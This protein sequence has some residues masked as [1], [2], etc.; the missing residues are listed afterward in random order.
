MRA[1]FS[2]LTAALR[3]TPAMPNL[4]INDVLPEL[5]HHLRRSP[6]TVLQAPPGAGKTT[7]VPLA[8]LAQEVLPDG[9]NIMMLEPRRLAA[10]SAAQRMADMLG[11]PLGRTVGY[12]VRGDSM[13]SEHT[14]ILVVTE[15]LL[16]RRLQTDPELRGFS[17]VIFDEF[18]ERSLHADLSLA[19][20]LQS[21]SAWREDLKLLLMSA[22]L[23][24]QAIAKLFDGAPIV[25]SAGRSYPV[26]IH[27][28]SP[29]EPS[30]DRHN[31]IGCISHLLQKIIAEHPGNI[32]VF[33]PGV[34]EIKQL[35]AALE[36][37]RDNNT[38]IAPLFGDLSKQQQHQAIAAPPPGQR[39]IVLA[40]NIAETSI[41]IDGITSVIDSGLMR[42]NRFD[43]NTGMNRLTTCRISRDSA[44]QRAGRA[45]RLSAGRCYRLWTQAQHQ[46]LAQHHSPEI[47]S[48]D[49]AP[50]VL[51]AAH[52]G[53]QDINEFS[54][55]DAPPPGA[56]AQAQDLLEQL[57]ALSR[58]MRI[59]QHGQSMLA[60]GIHPRLAH[61][62]LASVALGCPGQACL[63]A[64]LLSERDIFKPGTARTA[65]IA[66]RIQVLQ[67]GRKDP[68]SRP[69]A[70]QQVKQQAR[71]LQQK[72][73]TLAAHSSD[74]ADL[75][76][77]GVLLAHAY[78]ER[79]AQLR[80]N[81][82]QRYLLCG[83]KGA[84]FTQT[85]D[86]AHQ[87]YLVIAELDGRQRE[88]A[89]F[90]AATI[91]ADQLE[92]HF[93]ER[94]ETQSHIYW[95]SKQQR[96][97]AEQR[98]SLGAL[99]LS[100]SRMQDA[101]AEALHR[102]LLDGIREQGLDCLPWDKASRNL[103]ARINFL[104]QAEA[105][106]A[107]LR[108][109][110]PDYS[111]AHL[112]AHLDDWLLPHLNRHTSLDKLKT[113]KLYSI[114]HDT[115]SWE[116][117]QQLEQLAPS[118]FSVPS[119][120]RIPIDYTANPPV[121]AVRLQEMFGLQDTPS[122]LKQQVPLLIHLLSPASRPV[123]ITQDLK[124]FW[125]NTYADVKKELKIKYKKHHWPD[126]PLQAQA[127]RHAKTRRHKAK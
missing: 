56:V 1:V 84:C 90:S 53:A 11:E 52:W 95:D 79:I 98:R 83:G 58:P 105:T 125:A 104:K 112:L 88:A 80:S 4:P 89:I 97:I 116:V 2:S 96:V 87:D 26:D 127:T 23:N 50:L 65:D 45:G 81:K 78:P 55:L 121:L 103:C 76:L 73:R 110:L 47:L 20:C 57:G 16:T 13:R 49:L 30:I 5:L 63:L 126:D 19:L 61:M 8:V 85:D 51:E 12:Q 31:L 118:H 10:R 17:L 70:Y 82:D 15:G 60:L 124:S 33:L 111:N 108:Q 29:R 14:R 39:K 66:E 74:K 109:A 28:R 59:S 48:G 41:T 115:L 117:Q 54:W 91:S 38:L 25:Q 107:A 99:V 40:T 75:S 44:E 92:T 113:L 114:L 86:L 72:L 22:T 67:Q 123:Q 35:A 71:Q 32:L 43:P 77:I 34:G 120:S 102:A 106:P 46:Q 24:T 94:I 3:Y 27:Y 37:Q 6:N 100:S 21:Q 93:P 42:E 64:A 36:Q 9:G 119:G 101:P 68:R 62:L 7:A 122:I 69:S 18:H